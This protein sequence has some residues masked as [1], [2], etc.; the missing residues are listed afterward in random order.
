MPATHGAVHVST[1]Q[2]ACMAVWQCL[3]GVIGCTATTGQDV[4]LQ[5]CQNLCCTH[6]LK[7]SSTAAFSSALILPCNLPHSLPSPKIPV[8]HPTD[9]STGVCMRYGEWCTALQIIV[10]ANTV[11]P[12]Q[13]DLVPIN[14]QALPLATGLV[15]VSRVNQPAIIHESQLP[16]TE[17]PLQHAASSCQA[18]IPEPLSLANSASTVLTPS[19][20][21][22]PLSDTKGHT[23]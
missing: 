17:L 22:E 20:V 3:T 23:M 2:R 14:P 7:L 6:L 10:H 4:F 11:F 1:C 13:I 9:T 12:V 15:A 19:M 21:S 8:H 18:D 16:A 5:D